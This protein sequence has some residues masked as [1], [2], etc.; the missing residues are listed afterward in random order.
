MEELLRVKGKEALLQRLTLEAEDPKAPWGKIKKL[1]KGVWE[2]DRKLL[3][4]ILP[5]LLED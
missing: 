5:E 2:T 3:L 4:D 1:M